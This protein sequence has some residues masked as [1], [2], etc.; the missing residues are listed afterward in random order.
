MP[1]AMSPGV[2]NRLQNMHRPIL[3]FLPRMPSGFVLVSLFRD[4]IKSNLGYF[5]CL[6]DNMKIETSL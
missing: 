1:C 3:K 6:I 2:V 5:G 4:M